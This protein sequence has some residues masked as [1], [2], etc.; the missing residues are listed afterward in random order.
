MSDQEKPL[1]APVADALKSYTAYF[2]QAAPMA[3]ANTP[4]SQAQASD[5][6]LNQA[7]A[8]AAVLNNNLP[9]LVD[10][11]FQQTSDMVAQAQ[12]LSATADQLRLRAGRFRLESGEAASNVVPLRRAA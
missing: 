2:E 9:Q 1:A 6:I 8:P 3:I 12:E 7:A 11:N 10:V 4:E 5:L